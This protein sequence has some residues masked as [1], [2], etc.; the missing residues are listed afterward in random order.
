V[1]Q[2]IVDLAPHA[3]KQCLYALRIEPQFSRIAHET[4]VDHCRLL[5]RLI[6]AKL[7]ADRAAEH[8]LAV[9]VR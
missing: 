1:Q 4:S 2:A 9:R 3:R 5:P 6:D 8:A 7:N